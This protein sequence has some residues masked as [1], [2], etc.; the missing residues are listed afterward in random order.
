MARLILKFKD[1]VLHVYPLPSN[2]PFTIGRRTENDLVIDNLAVSGHHAR[3]ENKGEGYAIIDLQSKNGTFLNGK[4]VLESPLNHQDAVTIGK[5]TLVAD[6][7]DSIAVDVTMDS[8]IDLGESPE[9]FSDKRTMLLDTPVA[10]QMRGEEMP[11]PPPPEPEHPVT[12]QLSILSAASGG[13]GELI[14]SHKPITIGQNKDADIVVGGL[15]G[16]LTGSP[17]VTI[18]KQAGDVFLRFNGGLI[19][20]KRNG[21]GVK[22]TIKLNH[23]DIVEVGPVKL[24]VKL[25]K[26]SAP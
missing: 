3:I 14:L 9:S 20:P 1:R 24:Q 12:D 19:K 4:P 6:L 23:E 5:H 16:L 21:A 13:R 2:Q 7:T 26:R 25:S 10:R 22:G 18:S 17:A 11:P 15:W 8:G